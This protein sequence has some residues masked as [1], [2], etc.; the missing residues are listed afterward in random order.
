M[1]MAYYTLEHISPTPLQHQRQQQWHQQHQLPGHYPW[2]IGLLHASTGQTWVPHSQ[3][4]HHSSTPFYNFSFSNPP[5]CLSSSSTHNN[6]I[7]HLRQQNQLTSEA[8]I[9]LIKEEEINKNFGFGSNRNQTIKLMCWHWAVGLHPNASYES[10]T[11]SSSLAVV[12]LF[13]I[14]WLSYIFV[15][16]LSFTLPSN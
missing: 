11:P 1:G 3:I 12:L 4:G 2:T 8:A 9:I 6:G 13:V 15:L 7:L 5:S 10:E 16:S 14:V